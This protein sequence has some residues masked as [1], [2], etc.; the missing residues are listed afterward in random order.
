MPRRRKITLK[1]DPALSYGKIGRQYKTNDDAEALEMVRRLEGKGRKRVHFSPETNIRSTERR[2]NRSNRRGTRRDNRRG[3]Q[4]RYYP[5]PSG[6]PA[7]EYYTGTR[8]DKQRSIRRGTS[9]GTQGR[10]YA[11]PSGDPA[12]EYYTGTQSVNKNP[13]RRSTNI[14]THRSNHRVKQKGTRRDK[15]RSTH[16]NP[17]RRT[18]G[19]KQRS[20]RGYKQRGTHRDKQRK[21]YEDKVYRARNTE[22]AIRIVDAIK[23]NKQENIKNL[24]KRIERIRLKEPIQQ[25]IRQSRHQPRHQPRQ[26]LR[27]TQMRPKGSIITMNMK[28]FLNPEELVPDFVHFILGRS[29][30]EVAEFPGKTFSY[31]DLVSKFKEPYN[32]RLKAHF[33]ENTHSTIQWMFPTITTSKYAPNTSPI[34]P[35]SNKDFIRT[36]GEDIFKQVGNIIETAAKLYYDYIIRYKFLKLNYDHNF[37]RITRVANCL[38]YFGK[39]KTAK[40]ILENIIKKVTDRKGNTHVDQTSYRLWLNTLAGL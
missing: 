10:Y 35:R 36:Y 30:M 9:R 5:P 11:P 12:D 3:T 31:S 38:K 14:H 26:N 20:T 1:T 34:L 27:K 7:D 2:I 22:E 33:W 40:K 29:K 25:P 21:S 4:G 8:R 37:L 6:V 16:I 39:N 17:Q 32:G 24:N 23:M 15:Q 28:R 18:R 13:L 19:D